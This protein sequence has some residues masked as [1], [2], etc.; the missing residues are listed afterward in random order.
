[1]FFPSPPQFLLLAQQLLLLLLACGGGLVAATPPSDCSGVPMLTDTWTCGGAGCPQSRSASSFIAYPFDCNPTCTLEYDVTGASGDSIRTYVFDENEY[2]DWAAGLTA[3]YYDSGSYPNDIA[4]A[5]NIGPFTYLPTG[6]LYLV[7]DCR[8]SFYSCSFWY[9]ISWSTPSPSPAPASS[10]PLPSASPSPLPPPSPSPL[11]SPSPSPSGS[12]AISVCACGSSCTDCQTFQ[13]DTCQIAY[14]ICTG[15]L[16]GYL[17]ITGSPSLWT[18]A[19]YGNSDCSGTAP[20]SFASNCGVCNSGLDVSVSCPPSA[21]ATS[22]LT[23][24]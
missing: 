21:G 9:R 3:N 17:L 11:P 14:D 24:F 19:F 22:S 2:Y 15:E 20:L 1:M 10:W 18:G 23:L 5:V 7:F 8:N 6:R 16:L 12:E 13:T 4:C